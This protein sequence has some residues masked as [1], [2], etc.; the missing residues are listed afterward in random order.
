MLEYDNAD[1]NLIEC[2]I[3]IYRKSA[4][5]NGKNHLNTWRAKYIGRK[6]IIYIIE[7]NGARHFQ[8]HPVN[9]F[10]EVSYG[11]GIV[12]SRDEYEII[13]NELRITTKNSVYE[14]IIVEKI[15]FK[16]LPP[17]IW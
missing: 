17:I 8:W 14:F 10:D 7:Q 12:S 11:K 5:K 9:E 15:C 13:D 4:D 16:T 3:V 6:G 1:L 2:A